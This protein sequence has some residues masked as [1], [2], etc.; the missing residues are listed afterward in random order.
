MSAWDVIFKAYRA[1][2][3]AGE[4]DLMAASWAMR[5]LRAA[6]YRIL[7][8]GELDPETVERCQAEIE[9]ACDA[10][11]SDHDVI[12]VIRARVHSLQ[13]EKQ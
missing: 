6:G 8:P 3:R 13:G 7:A 9:V 12:R 5:D 2:A 4:S 1:S 11:L 10:D